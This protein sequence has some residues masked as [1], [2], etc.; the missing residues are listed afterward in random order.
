MSPEL[1]NECIEMEENVF[2]V[3]EDALNVKFIPKTDTWSFESFDRL[4]E[5]S[6]SASS[7]QQIDT[8][9]IFYNLLKQ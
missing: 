2:V 1:L 5:S 3:Y 7:F 9:N 8:L 4:L 6:S